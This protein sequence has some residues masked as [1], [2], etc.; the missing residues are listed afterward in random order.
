[1]EDKKRCAWPG[2][3][4][5]NKLMIKYH[6]EEWGVPVHDDK[7]LFEYFLLDTFQ[8]GLS[9]EIIL[10]K[11]ENFRKAFNNFNPI[12]I[13]GY[14]DQDRKRLLN[15]AGIVRNR[16]KIESAIVNAQKFLEIQKEFGA[17]DKYIWQFT[18]HKTIKNKF[19]ELK[20]LPSKTKESD[21][22]N[23]DLKERG[24]K[25][26][27]STICYAFMQGT[28]IVNDHLIDCFRYKELKE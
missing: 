14:T 9:W 24:F 18:K 21:A 1:M 2:K 12:K 3:E 5:K 26:V 13:A 8:A 27:G 25:F 23:K 10:K 20:E 7:K 22:M 15:D 11:R 28:G 16:L 6:D 4:E 19:K 17:F